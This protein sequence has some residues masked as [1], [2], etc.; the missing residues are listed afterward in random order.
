[1]TVEYLALD[2]LLTPAADLGVSQV[3]DVGLLGAPAAVLESIVRND[4]LIDGNERLGWIATFVFR[5][6]V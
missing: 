4:P 2:D 6:T 1:V 3:C 5:F